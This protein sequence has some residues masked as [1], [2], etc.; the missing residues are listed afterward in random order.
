M[1]AAAYRK[2]GSTVRWHKELDSPKKKDVKLEDLYF[3]VRFAN[4][5]KLSEYFINF[6]HL[7]LHIG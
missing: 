1:A 7:E 4:F 5:N 3:F 6:S 2:R